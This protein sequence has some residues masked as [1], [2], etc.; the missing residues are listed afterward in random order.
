MRSTINKYHNKKTTID[1]I[2][3]DSKAEAARWKELKLMER[4]GIITELHR[5]PVFD[6]TPN[7]RCN[8]HFYR[9]MQYIADFSYKENGILV[10]EDVKG[11]RTKEYLIKRKLMAWV[12]GIEIREV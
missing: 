9:R 4:A 11:V 2:T 6:L 8:G 12:H 3:F 1:G 7:F 10:V 5:Q